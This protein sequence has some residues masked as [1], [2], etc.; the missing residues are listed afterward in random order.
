LYYGIPLYTKTKKPESKED[1]SPHKPDFQTVDT[2]SLMRDLYGR[3]A[4]VTGSARG[5]GRAI[6]ACL[7]EHGAAVTLSDIDDSAGQKAKKE[8]TDAGY[9]SDFVQADV[10]NENDVVG[11]VKS[12]TDHF[13]A[14]DILVNNAG[15]VSTPGILDVD[16]SQLATSIS[17]SM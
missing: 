14:V 17:P 8:L 3:T 12:A 7:A 10:S 4:I 15:I 5:I 2:E 1:E 6:A 9:R 16:L 11:F 13:G